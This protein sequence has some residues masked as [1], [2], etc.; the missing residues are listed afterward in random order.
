MAEQSRLQSDAW[1]RDPYPRS[2]PFPAIHPPMTAIRTRTQFFTNIVCD[3]KPEV[4]NDALCAQLQKEIAAAFASQ[5]GYAGMDA[6]K[7]SPRLTGEHQVILTIWW[8][9][10][11][12]AE[13]GTASLNA[14]FHGHKSRLGLRGYWIT[15]IPVDTGWQ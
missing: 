5:D 8:D 7:T 10:K 15:L 1:A 9:S 14:W 11:K 6:G 4:D 3:V 13:E 12:H 2:G